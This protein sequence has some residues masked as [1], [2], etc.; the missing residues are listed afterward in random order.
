MTRAKSSTR[1]AKPPR[2][3][4]LLERR[5]ESQT[6]ENVIAQRLSGVTDRGFMTTWR[7]ALIQVIGFAAYAAVEEYKQFDSAR[8]ESRTMGV[9]VQMRPTLRDL[10]YE[11]RIIHEEEG[12]SFFHASAGLLNQL[13]PTTN[14]QAL[15]WR[16]K[17][18]EPR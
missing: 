4:E 11:I 3:W 18:W 2:P 5:H 8:L 13:T 14:P 9:V 7:C 17:C 6:W 15:A 10:A 1:I 12:P 16:A